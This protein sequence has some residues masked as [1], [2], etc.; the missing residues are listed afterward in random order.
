MINPKKRN[1]NMYSLKIQDL[2]ITY[3]L[4]K[5]HYVLRREDKL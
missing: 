5:S 2:V 4:V 1:M 3:I